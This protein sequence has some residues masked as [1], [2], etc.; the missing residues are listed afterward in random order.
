MWDQK[1]QSAIQSRPEFETVNKKQRKVLSLSVQLF[2][3]SGQCDLE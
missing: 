2:C 3:Y 1:A